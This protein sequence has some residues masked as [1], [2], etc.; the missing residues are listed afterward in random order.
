MKSVSI[1]TLAAVGTVLTSLPRSTLASLNAGS[2]DLT[3]AHHRRF[4]HR[5]QQQH[6][7]HQ[8]GGTVVAEPVENETEDAQVTSLAVREDDS[9]HQ[10]AKRGGY[11]GRATFFDPGLGACG[12][13]SGAG[14]YVSSFFSLSFPF[15]SFIQH[16]L[17]D[18]FLSLMYFLSPDDLLFFLSLSDG[19]HES[20]TVW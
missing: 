4:H 16:S 12:T 14:D 13:Y 8:P 6:Q 11:N 10:L 3:S 1:Y 20:S 9:K 17:F 2:H 19:S 5:Q 7:Q 15:L 18:A